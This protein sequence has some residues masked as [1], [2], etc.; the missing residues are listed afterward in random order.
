MSGPHEIRVFGDPVLRTPCAP[1]TDIDAVIVKLAEDM[2]E[3]MYAS[4]GVGVA[5]PQVGVSKAMFVY[6]AGSGPYVLINPNVI[7]TSGEWEYEEGCLS[8]PNMFFPIV[9]PNHVV[10]EGLDL[11]GKLQHHE[12]DEFTG[13]VFQHEADHLNGMLLLSRL[14]PES[15]KLAMRQLRERQINQSS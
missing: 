5:A 7:E 9:R 6:D 8:V 2:I 15:K 1:I 14:D 3:T 13:R 11:D 10:L 4:H 12:V